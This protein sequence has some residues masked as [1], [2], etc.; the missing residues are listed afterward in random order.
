MIQGNKEGEEGK[1]NEESE[2]NGGTVTDIICVQFTI[3]TPNVHVKGGA[4]KELFAFGIVPNKQVE[5][6]NKEVSLLCFSVYELV[7]IILNLLC[8]FDRNLA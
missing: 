3:S 8:N 6:A 4:E 2:E 5:D 7:G 1:R